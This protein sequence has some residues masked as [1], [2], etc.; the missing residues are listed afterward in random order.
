MDVRNPN[1]SKLSILWKL[2]PDFN[3]F[4]SVTIWLFRHTARSLLKTL[5]HVCRRLTKHW[6]I[7]AFRTFLVSQSIAAEKPYNLSTKIC[8]KPYS[9]PWLLKLQHFMDILP[10]KLWLYFKLSELNFIISTTWPLLFEFQ[11]YTFLLHLHIIFSPPLY[12][13]SFSSFS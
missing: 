8:K 7:V 6:F 4:C 5:K 3:W 10:S 11:R 1:F 2:D 12:L 13:I 9:S